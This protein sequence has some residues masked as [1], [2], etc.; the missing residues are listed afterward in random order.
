MRGLRWWLAVAAATLLAFCGCGGDNPSDGSNASAPT[1]NAATNANT[2][3]GKTFQF[4]VTMSYNFSE[5]VGAV[6]TIDFHPDQGYTFHPSPQN[7]EG[8][9]LENGTFTYDADTGLIHFSRPDHQDIDGQFTFS[10]PTG[11]TVRLMGPEG[12]IEEAN[13]EQVG[14]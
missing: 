3:A 7:H 10:S 11:G 14:G 6:Y 13:F 2:L 4:T 1:N 9:N 5:P 12:E 8:L